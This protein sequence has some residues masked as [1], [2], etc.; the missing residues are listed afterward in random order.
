MSAQPYSR[1]DRN[2]VARDERPRMFRGRE[3]LYSI[4]IP[5]G[6]T[7]CGVVQADG[8]I[9]WE[10]T[11]SNPIADILA[12]HERWKAATGGPTRAERLRKFD[13]MEIEVGHHLASKIV[14][15]PLSMFLKLNDL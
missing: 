14:S 10:D 6:F 9:R 13:E 1:A 3:I 5:P 15:P 4:F 8:A 11:A 2:R 12:E 7:A